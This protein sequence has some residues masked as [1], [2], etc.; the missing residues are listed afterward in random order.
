MR[1]NVNFNNYRSMEQSLLSQMNERL[2]PNKYFKIKRGMEYEAYYKFE[3]F[4]LDINNPFVGFI[5][6]SDED[7]LSDAKHA[8]EALTTEPRTNVWMARHI[9]GDILFFK[10]KPEMEE[11]EQDNPEQNDPEQDDTAQ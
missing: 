6:T 11:V 3:H 10:E 4:N 5:A 8:Y 1:Y 2:G 7:F 9:S